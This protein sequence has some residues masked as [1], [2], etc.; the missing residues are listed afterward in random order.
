MDGVEADMQWPVV[1]VGAPGFLDCEGEV[2]VR[3]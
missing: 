2:G 3:V 1:K